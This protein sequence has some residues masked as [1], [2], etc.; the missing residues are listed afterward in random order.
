MLGFI[1]NAGSSSLKVRLIDT[2][3]K[4]SLYEARAEHLNSSSAKLT[5]KVENITYHLSIAEKEK[6]THEEALR[7]VVRELKERNVI[8]SI[9]EISFIG[10][11]I[12][13]GG[14]CF[15]EATIITDDVIDEIASCKTLAP[16]HNPVGIL[17][18]KYCKRLFPNTIQ[19]AVFDTAFHQTVPEINFRYAI[20]DKFFYE[21]IR[22]YG[23]HGTSY[24][25]L[26]RVLAEKIGKQNISA[27]MAH[28]GQ[29][30]SVCA[31]NRGKSIYTSMEFSPLSGCIMGTRSGSI[32]PSV[33]QF[34]CE[35]FGYSV[36]YAISILN[37]ESGLLALTG[38]NNMV[39]IIE[40]VNQNKKNCV[41]AL[42]YFC[43]SIANS[44]AQAIVELEEMPKQ[45]VFTGGI[46][47]NSAIVRENILAY[48]KPIIGKVS[49]ASS[50]DYVSVNGLFSSFKKKNNVTV[51][52]IQTNE[53]LEIALEAEKLLL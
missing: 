3:S 42:N 43:K 41:F 27:V 23:F 25:Y 15:S 30:T 48:L 35:N 4:K 18:I 10:H 5:T 53:E 19:V 44:I 1:V 52:V 16:L 29:G 50:P 51:Y 26:T 14:S 20:P 45:I 49:Y 40:G 12:V 37:K 8:S 24:A 21:G 39:E 13:H 11:R 9:E 31:V 2:K 22:K 46:G 34:L 28:I 7:I 38:T 17:G 32:D 36:E 6:M 47:E 33:I